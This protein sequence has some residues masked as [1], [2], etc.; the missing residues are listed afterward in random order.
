MPCWRAAST[1]AW[2]RARGDAVGDDH[3][4]GVVEVSLFVEV[5][6]LPPVGA[7]G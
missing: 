6:G 2:A 1:A 4:L 7:V 3:D 5:E